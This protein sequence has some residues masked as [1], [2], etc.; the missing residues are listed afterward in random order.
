MGTDL[1]AAK[2]G[3]YMGTNHACAGD[4]IA[5]LTYTANLFP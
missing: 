4:F 3:F 5:T 1:S 2:C